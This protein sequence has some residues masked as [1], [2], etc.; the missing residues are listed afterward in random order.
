MLKTIKPSTLSPWQ[1]VC[2]REDW[3]RHK[4]LPPWDN[5]QRSSFLAGGHQRSQGS[6]PATSTSHEIDKMVGDFETYFGVL[7]QSLDA[8]KKRVEVSKDRLHGPGHRRLRFRN[9][10][11]RLRLANRTDVRTPT[12]A[13]RA[14]DKRD[15]KAWTIIQ[16]YGTRTY[17]K[18]PFNIDQRPS[19]Q[20]RTAAMVERR[21]ILKVSL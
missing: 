7:K 15:E 11:C 19:R 14:S 12:N 4:I 1:I 3:V 20:P 13:T 21:R 2:Y 8:F 10:R 9:N 17:G 18:L 16:P 6:I 5:V